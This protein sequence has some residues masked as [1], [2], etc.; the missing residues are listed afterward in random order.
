MLWC[1]LYGISRESQFRLTFLSTVVRIE[2]QTCHV[3]SESFT[4]V[5]VYYNDLVK[6]HC[7][8]YEAMNKCK[9]LL[10]SCDGKGE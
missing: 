8:V 3:L 6:L 9:I 10:Y 7:H 4:T 2:P 1:G 5:P